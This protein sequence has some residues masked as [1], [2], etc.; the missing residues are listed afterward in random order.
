MPS[1]SRERWETERRRALDEL[2]R[3]RA[4]M[5]GRGAGVRVATQ[6]LNQAYAMLLSSHFQGYCRDLHQEAVDHLSSH[7]S[8]PAVQALTRRQ[9]LMGRRLD[10]G[11][12]NPGNL[13]ADFARLGLE[14]WPSLRAY[15]ARAALHLDRLQGL[16]A[17]R[18]AIAHQD[19]TSPQLG[20]RTSLRVTDVRRW[21]STCERLVRSLE[22]VVGAHVASLVGVLPW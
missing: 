9:L 16:G 12:P 4:S 6:Q 2:E 22:A 14:L 1:R 5:L 3:V 21:R 8:P 18:N 11:N 13:G 17:W 7:I 19:F 10:V 15:V 20:G